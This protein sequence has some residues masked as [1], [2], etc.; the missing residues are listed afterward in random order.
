MGQRVQWLSACLSKPS[1]AQYGVKPDMWLVGD[2]AEAGE[3]VIRQGP[4]SQS[5]LKGWGWA[6]L[7]NYTGTDARTLEGIKKRCRRAASALR[8]ME[9]TNKRVARKADPL[10]RDRTEL[11]R[12]GQISVVS[13][14]GYTSEFQA[15]IY[16]L[17]AEE[18]F[19]KKVEDQL[20]LPV[21]FVLEEAHNFAPAQ[22][23]S[24]AEKRSITTTR[25]IAQEGRKFGVGQVI[26]SHAHPGWTR[27]RS[28]N[29]TRS[30]S[31]VW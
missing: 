12:Y 27:R 9:D 22:P 28:H 17:I 21:L 19:A 1:I 18:I 29:A 8:R 26:I 7:A 15:T 23:R 24:D 4:L 16:S 13:L 14:A 20:R 30:S 11:V 31:C 5:E 10:P 2:L 6:G 3:L 25:Q